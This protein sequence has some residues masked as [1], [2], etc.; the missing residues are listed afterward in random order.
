MRHY[1][2]I[3][4]AGGTQHVLFVIIYAAT[5]NTHKLFMLESLVPPPHDK[6][7]EVGLRRTSREAFERPAHV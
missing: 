4:A 1:P 6:D 3:T 5:L 7:G 2:P